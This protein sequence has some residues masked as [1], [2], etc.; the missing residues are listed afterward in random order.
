MLGNQ[1]FLEDARKDT[2]T[3]I[4]RA[5]LREDMKNIDFSGT[6]VNFHTLGT[7]L[8]EL[9][10][11]KEDYDSNGWQLDL[12]VTY[13]KEGCEKLTIHGSAFVFEIQLAK[14]SYFEGE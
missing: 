8:E 6:G 12:T 9:G 1:Y 2:F 3:K 4:V 14:Q 11:T 7:I 5:F 10:Y 13:V